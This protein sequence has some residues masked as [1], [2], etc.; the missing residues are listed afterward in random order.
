MLFQKGGG[1]AAAKK[2]RLFSCVAF[3]AGIRPPPK[4]HVT[5]E[6]GTRTICE[7]A[8]VLSHRSMGWLGDDDVDRY[9]QA[10]TGA[11]DHD[12]RRHVVRH[13]V[14]GAGR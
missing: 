9:I 2:R 4:D 7:M 11:A 14:S 5:A 6:C 1:A 3:V 12:R 10:S 8:V 13:H